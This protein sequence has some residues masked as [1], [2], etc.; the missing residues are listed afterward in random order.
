MN[1]K[2]VL[3]Q[4]LNVKKGERDHFRYTIVKIV[5]GYRISNPSKY[6]EVELQLAKNYE[7]NPYTAPVE[8]SVEPSGRNLSV[9]TAPR[10]LW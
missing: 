5:I 1:V 7:P 4:L 2:T 10:P 3:F 9:R 6:S 8:P